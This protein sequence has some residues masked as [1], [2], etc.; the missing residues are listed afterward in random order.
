M[1]SDE[2]IKEEMSAEDKD[3]EE[4]RKLLAGF[5]E[6]DLAML[7]DDLA[8]HGHQKLVFRHGPDDV[9]P[10]MIGVGDGPIQMVNVLATQYYCYYYC[11]YYYY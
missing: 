5:D 1:F 11:Y 6:P 3:A 8:P 9:N 4:V 10:K 7:I 2:D